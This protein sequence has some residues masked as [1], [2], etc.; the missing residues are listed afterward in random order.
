MKRRKKKERK[1][2]F[3]KIN[4][5]VIKE[6]TQHSGTPGDLFLEHENPTK[7]AKTCF[8]IHKTKANP[9]P[10]RAPA[11]LAHLITGKPER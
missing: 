7:S 9:L 2:R 11:H 8:N 4:Q 6:L 10:K 3:K 1:I 5:K